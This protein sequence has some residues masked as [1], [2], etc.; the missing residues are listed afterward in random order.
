MSPQINGLIEN[1]DAPAI[2]LLAANIVAPIVWTDSKE[3]T[4]D[5]VEL[6][7]SIRLGGSLGFGSAPTG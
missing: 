6:S 3:F 1:D 5:A 2:D 7:G 4:I